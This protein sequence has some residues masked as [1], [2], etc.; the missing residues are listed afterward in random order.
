MIIV[1]HILDCGQKLATNTL[2]RLMDQLEERLLQNDQL[3]PL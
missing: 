1:S 3:K 2:K